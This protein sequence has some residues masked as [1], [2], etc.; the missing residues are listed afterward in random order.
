M[1]GDRVQT[2][3]L[4]GEPIENAG[5]PTAGQHLVRMRGAD[6]TRYRVVG[7]L[8]V[9]LGGVYVV[10]LLHRS[11]FYVDDFYRLSE[12][13][14]YSLGW[15][16]LSLSV[17]G[18]F[19]PGWRLVFMFLQ[20][21]A[22]FDYSWVIAITTVIQVATLAALHD[23]LSGLFGRRWLNP[24]LVAAYAISPAL[25][26]TVSWFSNTLHVM[27]SLLCVI[28]A[29]DGFVRYLSSG[30]RRWIVLALVVSP[31]GLMF[32]EKTALLLLVMPLII[33]MISTDR[34]P[35]LAGVGGAVK[36]V[37]RLV[38]IWLS[39]AA[40]MGVYFWYYFSHHYYMHNPRPSVGLFGRAT[41]RAWTHG[42]GTSLVGGPYTWHYDYP[43]YGLAQPARWAIRL[44]IACL[45]VTVTVS[46][47]MRR[48]SWRGWV[49]AAVCFTASF[50]L[51][52]FGRLTLYGIAIGDNLAYTSDAL[53]FVLLGVAFAFL[54]VDRR[55]LS[56]SAL[57]SATVSPDRIPAP[58][59]GR[60]I[61]H[62]AT[63]R[64]RHR[65]L[66]S[67]GLW[68]AILG[69]VGYGIG[70][71]VSV[72]R[73]THTWDQASPRHYITNLVASVDHL[74]RG[75]QPFSVIDVD[76][77]LTVELP[78]F[79]INLLSSILHAAR[80][81]VSYDDASKPL[82]LADPKSGRLLPAVIA[83]VGGVGSPQFLP[84]ATRHGSQECLPSGASIVRIAFGAT[85]ASGLHYVWM[86]YDAHASV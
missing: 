84:G 81:N 77:P 59:A 60:R 63:S 10:A 18:H 50:S 69:L 2:G 85:K 6:P 39:F 79:P 11:F 68:V 71:G 53:P 74:R 41:W 52:A 22:P 47:M 57:A 51:V 3:T 7:V 13:S 66:T 19:V 40:P 73:F 17:F 72:T 35:L 28:A 16:Y 43:G 65:P 83:R 61:L 25:I 8:V 54:P 20:R 56:G 86:T 62:G 55:L 67:I 9:L 34:G 30:Q 70:S 15:K 82:Y 29:L 37:F 21:Q 5:M 12:A 64:H 48:R 33:L 75:G 76:V 4:L 38:P 49:F 78:G 46:L 36:R 31:I 42:V 27:T 44:G 1:S 58:S 23:L 32:Y 80:P 26:L 24:V 14:S 45:L